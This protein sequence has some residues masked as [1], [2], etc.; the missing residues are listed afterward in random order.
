MIVLIVLAVM[1][2]AFAQDEQ[3]LFN[4]NAGKRYLVDTSQ[5]TMTTALRLVTSPF[6][7]LDETGGEARTILQGQGRPRCP[8]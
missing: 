8:H 3:H 6:T 2:G 4:M 7:S 1:S 5:V